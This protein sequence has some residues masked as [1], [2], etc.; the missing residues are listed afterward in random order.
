MSVHLRIFYVG[1]MQTYA[2][3][4]SGF[5]DGALSSAKFNYPRGIE[6]MTTGHIFI[7]DGNNNAVR[8]INAGIV[9]Y[10][11]Q[12]TAINVMR[13]R[14]CYYNRWIPFGDLWLI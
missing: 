3:S 1:L 6:M 2:G 4:T 12:N 7:A 11:R 9:L 8:M 10:T 14:T 5:S 13:F